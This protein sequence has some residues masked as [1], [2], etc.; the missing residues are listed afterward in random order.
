MTTLNGA[1]GEGMLFLRHLLKNWL[2]LDTGRKTHSVQV[3]A[4][5]ADPDVDSDRRP[6]RYGGV[7]QGSSPREPSVETDSV[8]ARAGHARRTRVTKQHSWRRPDGARDPS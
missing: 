4:A 5:L 8:L 1:R 6:L 7:P 2:V 3:R